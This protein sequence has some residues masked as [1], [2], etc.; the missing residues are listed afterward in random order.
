MATARHWLTAARPLAQANIAGPLVLGQALAWAMT[1][2]FSV[3]AAVAVHTFGALDHLFIVFANDYADRDAD[4][5]GA[6]TL[7]SG[8]SGVLPR[9][10][11]GATTLRWAAVVMAASLL[12][13]GGAMAA[14]ERPGF[15]L[16]S[17]LAVVLLYAYSYGPLRLSYRGGG[18]FLQA[19]G[20]GV[21]LPALGYY[22]QAGDMA[23]FPH[24]AWAP[25]FLLGF[26]GNLTTAL[27]D[28]AS[29]RAAK[30][31]TWAVRF[32]EA[33]ARGASLALIAGAVM[34]IAL[35]LDGATT[36]ARATFTAV[37]LGPLLANLL[38]FRRAD[39]ANRRACIGF[40][41]FNG[42]AISVGLFGWA[43]VLVL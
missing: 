15:L 42:L 43:L 28:T 36:F 14:F 35:S 2:R 10:E 20:L 32:G 24:I 30:K 1:G 26:A 18:E 40:V 41:F 23:D 11:L 12:A 4:V 25:L 9:G 6:Q 39:S 19:L 16:A 13:L 27:P 22:G 29:D 34:L 21:V 17:L 33:K 7:F 31:R 5:V 37:A 3:S 8:G 38:L